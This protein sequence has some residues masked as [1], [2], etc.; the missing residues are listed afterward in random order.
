[1]QQYPEVPSEGFGFVSVSSPGPVAMLFW[2]PGIDR[3]IWISGVV[4]DGYRMLFWLGCGCMS[5]Y[6]L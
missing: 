1:M 3:S 6:L 4:L 5:M 2:V